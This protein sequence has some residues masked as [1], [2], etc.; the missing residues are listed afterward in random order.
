[1]ALPSESDAL[2]ERCDRVKAQGNEAFKKER[3]AHA[4]ERYTAALNLARQ[5]NEKPA[6]GLPTRVALCLANRSQVHLATEE[7]PYADALKDAEEC[8]REGPGWP[9]GF[10]RLGQVYMKREEYMKAY[11]AFKQGWHLDMSNAELTKACQ[12]A[13]EAMIS[14]NRAKHAPKA[15]A[16][17]TAPA[18]P[19]PPAH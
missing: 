2:L 6:K 4:R 15:L 14:K 13:H 8:T 16:P 7:P 11:S 17:S 3:H 1:M 19:A 12:D 9:K 10:Y 18:A 5:A